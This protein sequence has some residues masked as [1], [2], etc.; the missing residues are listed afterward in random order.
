MAKEGKLVLR[1]NWC[2][3]CG[4]CVNACPK[5]ALSIGHD[6]NPDGYQFVVVDTEKCVLCGNCYT[7]CP[8]YVFS[9]VKDDESC[10]E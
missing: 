1:Q 2:K 3:S 9:L 5:K 10:G 8:D 6:A 4:L 7:I